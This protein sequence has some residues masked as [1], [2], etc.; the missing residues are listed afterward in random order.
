[1][2]NQNS[3]PLDDQPTPR[4]SRKGRRGRDRAAQ[5]S[6][7]PVFRLPPYHVDQVF[8]SQAETIDWGMRFLQAPT[9]WGISK[10]AGAR[11]CILDTGVAPNHTDLRTAVE[12]AKSFVRSNSGTS[13]VAGHGCVAPHD[14]LYTSLHGIGTAQ[15]FFHSAPGVAHFLDQTTVVKDVSG[16]NIRTVSA[17]PDGKPVEARVLAVHKLHHQGKVYQVRTSQ[18]ELTLTPWHPVY[19]I[20]SS[21]GKKRRLEKR[22][23]DQLT[24][25]DRVL[26]SGPGP[27]IGS[28]QTLPWQRRWVCTHCGYQARREARK[29]CRGCNKTNWHQGPTDQTLTLGEDL[30]SFLGMVVTDGHLWKNQGTV[31]FS[32]KDA[33]QGE[34]F[35]TLAQKLFGKVPLRYQ[36][37]RTGIASWRLNDVDSHRLLAQIGIPV[38]KKSLSATVPDIITRSPRVVI[39]AYVGGLLE[40]NGSVRARLRLGTGSCYFARILRTLLQSVGV[41]CSQSSQ[42]DP[43]SGVPYHMLR[44]AGDAQIAQ[45]V[46]VKDATVVLP[47]KAR[48]S[49]RVVGIEIQDYDGPMYDLTVEG[50]HNYVANGHIVSNTHCA[51]IVAARENSS[52]V[53]GIAPEATLLIGKVLGDDGS[54]SMEG[55]VAGID[56]AIAQKADVLSM[57]LGSPTGAPQL[58]AAIARALAA[59]LIV[60]CAAG[61][62]G[63]GPD[64]VG[65]PAQYPGV[66]SVASVGPDKKVSRF[67]SRGRRVDVAAPG[68][69]ILSCWPPN[70]LA[71]LSGTSMATPFVAGIAALYVS[72]CRKAGKPVSAVAFRQLLLQTAEDLGPPGFDNDY[73]WGLV[74]PI[75]L[76]KKQDAPAPGP[77]HP[78]PNQPVVMVPDDFTPAGLGKVNAA[79]GQSDWEQVAL[80]ATVQEAKAARASRVDKADKAA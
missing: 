29:Q 35:C 43:R 12:K 48:V 70:A 68:E 75:K 56:W 51:G 49:A 19:V 28:P 15:E 52:G 80:L 7:E 54:G 8:V 5:P 79:V 69:N 17:D 40:G 2:A 39:A 64:T 32:N 50:T 53:I 37:K 59:G 4:G 22:R 57:S 78:G 46:L 44:I 25:D 34:R 3:N 42:V 9:L 14:V 16:Y 67:S 31:E 60:C 10:G 61:N 55:I 72:V 65:Y 73:G 11:V 21:T 47:A 76:I 71:K 27:D 30:A 23:A 24:L 41:R 77:D 58:A 74:A 13:D 36:D 6:S 63:P 38:G 45:A 1:M 62:E 20:R 26:L 66:I 18:G 33:R